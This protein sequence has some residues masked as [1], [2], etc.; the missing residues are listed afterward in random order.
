MMADYLGWRFEF[1]IQL[2]LLVPAL[3][4]AHFAIPADLGLYGKESEP[5][6]MDVRNFDFRG[7]SLLTLAIT[8]LILGLVGFPFFDL[9]VE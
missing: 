6:I 5:V 1:A 8:F 7:S 2:V 4:I 3:V 9:N